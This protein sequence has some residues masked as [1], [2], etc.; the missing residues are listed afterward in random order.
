MKDNNRLIKS[1]RTFTPV[2]FLS[3]TY[4]CQSGHAQYLTGPVANGLGGAGRAAVDEGEQILLNPAT[5]VH[6]TPMSSSLFYQDGYAEKNE[7]DTALGLTIVDNT[8]DLFLSGGYAFVKRRRTFENFNS[9][10]EN[11][12]QLSFGRFVSSH[13]SVGAALTYLE[14]DVTDGESYKQWD[15]HVGL[16]YNPKPN[17][18]LAALFYNLSPRKDSIPAEIQNYNNIV[19][20]AHYLFMPMM[21]L[22]LDVGMQQVYNP[23]HN[24]HIQFGAESRISQFSAIRFGVDNDQLLDRTYYTVGLGFDG[25]RLKLDYFYRKNQDFNQGA[26][27]GVDMRLPFW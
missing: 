26:L 14:T 19:L 12:H 16:H 23:D 9:R 6:A 17:L 8:E 3:L 13:F 18:G 20:A 21:R 22:R 10:D 7:H 24:V 1:L 2:I 27:H 15:G 25:P 4:F 5:I 11:Y